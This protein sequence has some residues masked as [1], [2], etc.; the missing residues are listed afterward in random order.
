MATAVF[1]V[2]CTILVYYTVYGMCMLPKLKLR[3][4]DSESLSW[5]LGYK[6]VRGHIVNH[7][8]YMHILFS[9]DYGL[10]N[11][12]EKFYTEPSAQYC[13]LTV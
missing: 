3:S 4:N 12:C 7:L 6:E 8:C 13:K 11:I 9:L 2:Y 1:Y 5:I 10:A